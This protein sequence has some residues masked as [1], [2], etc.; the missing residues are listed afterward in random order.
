[1]R[2][3][4]PRT[5]CL[6]FINVYYSLL[7]AESDSEVQYY[8]SIQLLSNS[9]GT[10]LGPG[11]YKKCILLAMKCLVQ[12]TMQGLSWTS[13]TVAYISPSIQIF[14]CYQHSI[15]AP[16]LSVTAAVLWDRSE[17]PARQDN[18]VLVLGLLQMS[19][20]TWLILRTQKLT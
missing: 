20:S 3:V 18:L 16:Y 11:I 4:L 6:N 14:P 12:T 2:S 7:Y 13:G 1:M 19:P 15:N 9:K 5:A 10:K 8:R 17:Q